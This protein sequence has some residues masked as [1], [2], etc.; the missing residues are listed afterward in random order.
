[1]AGEGGA[2]RLRPPQVAQ[3]RGEDAAVAVVVDLNGCV[4]AAG[5]LEG[6]RCA[7]APARVDLDALTRRQRFAGQDVVGL[8]ALEAQYRGALTFEELLWQHSHAHQVGAEDAL[9]TLGPHGLV[10]RE[11]GPL[12]RSGEART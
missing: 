12:A 10:A 3:H 8:G 6:E 11:V 2:C 1:A 9:R 4:E 7:V 5:D